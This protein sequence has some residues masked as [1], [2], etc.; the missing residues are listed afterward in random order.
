MFTQRVG[1]WFASSCAVIVAGSL[2][3][4]MA[5]PKQTQVCPDPCPYQTMT[6]PLHNYVCCCDIT[7]APNSTWVCDCRALDQC[8]DSPGPPLLRCYGATTY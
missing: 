8:S 1:E 3:M 5:E 2:A 6:C 7:G 4:G